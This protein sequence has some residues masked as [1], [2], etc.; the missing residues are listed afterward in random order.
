[1]TEINYMG[2][3]CL[4]QQPVFGNPHNS[5]V[6]FQSNCSDWLHSEDNKESDTI[7]DRYGWELFGRVRDRHH[8]ST[9]SNLRKGIDIFLLLL[10]PSFCEREFIQSRE[11]SP[12]KN[13]W[14]V[15]SQFMNTV[16]SSSHASGADRIST[17][18]QTHQA[19][20]TG[21]QHA[22]ER[23]WSHPTLGRR[24]WAINLQTSPTWRCRSF[25]KKLIYTC[26]CETDRERE[27]LVFNHKLCRIQFD[28]QKHGFDA[29]VYHVET[30]LLSSISSDRWYIVVHSF[31]EKVG[32][33]FS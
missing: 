26:I 17:V 32:I 27:R 25:L 2:K 5:K 20:N 22:L 16:R 23:T 6:G 33:Q 30:H 10:L 24:T 18:S 28:H 7:K 15:S 29:R 21:R 12:G 11:L 8:M 31:T 3:S 13:N 4:R 1:M 14:C 19:L 9:F